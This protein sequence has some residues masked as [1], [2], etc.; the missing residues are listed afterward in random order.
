MFFTGILLL[1]SGAV[2][3]YGSP[4]IAVRIQKPDPSASLRLKMIGMLL[5]LI[6]A[7]M[8]FSGEIPESIRFIKKFK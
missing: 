5:A 4:L 1:L 6:G 2:L 7:W 8:I 3:I